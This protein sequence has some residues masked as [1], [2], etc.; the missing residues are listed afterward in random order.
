MLRVELGG[1]GAHAS[2]HACYARCRGV[3]CCAVLVVMDQPML[4][5]PVVV[6]TWTLWSMVKVTTTYCTLCTLG[7]A[8]LRRSS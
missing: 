3:L 8:P 1:E 4:D 5:S 7:Y 2:N 6:L